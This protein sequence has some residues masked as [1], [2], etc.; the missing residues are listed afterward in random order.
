MPSSNNPSTLHENLLT[1][2]SLSSL[3]S[4]PSEASQSKP[5]KLQSQHE[6]SAYTSMLLAALPLPPIPVRCMQGEDNEDAVMSS[7]DL[8]ARCITSAALL[9]LTSQEHDNNLQCK[10]NLLE[11]L[12]LQLQAVKFKRGD[13]YAVFADTTR[14]YI[15]VYFPEK[16]RKHI[17]LRVMSVSHVASGDTVL[18][19]AREHLKAHVKTL[20]ECN[21]LTAVASNRVL[22][23]L[24]TADYSGLLE[25]YVEVILDNTVPD[26]R[27]QF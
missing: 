20:Y 23:R 9:P 5:Q 11:A 25:L 27:V 15:S 7:H 2:S 8:L 3:S 4:L 10:Q 24:E 26:T 16:S 13:V 18:N 19:Q 22:S 17:D 12:P 21:E 14:E 6:A 1:Q